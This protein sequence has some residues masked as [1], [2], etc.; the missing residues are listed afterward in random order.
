VDKRIRNI[1]FSQ[2]YAKTS[3]DIDEPYTLESI[4]NFI[5][6]HYYSLQY[7]HSKTLKRM[8]TIEP[9]VLLYVHTDHSSLEAI[10]FNLAAQKLKSEILCVATPVTLDKHVKK[11]MRFLG[12]IT[13]HTKYSWD[14][15]L[16]ELENK[17]S[18]E[19]P[20]KE[21]SQNEREKELKK[22]FNPLKGGSLFIL[23][24]NED[25]VIKFKWD[26]KTQSQKSLMDISDVIN[27]FNDWRAGILKP[28]FKSMPL[29]TVKNEEDSQVKVLVGENFEQATFQ[30]GKDVVVFFHSVY[31]LECP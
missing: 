11:L 27:F 13:P 14:V 23:D 28:F 21:K 26:G 22:Y 19:N 16:K 8:M 25:R 10:N 2:H 7:L 17:P 4:T 20:G 1:T 29:E 18:R 24:R 6:S 12:I 30:N 15:D 5:D 9:A 3:Y 31:C